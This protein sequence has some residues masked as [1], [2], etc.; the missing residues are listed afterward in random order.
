MDFFCNKFMRMPIWLLL[1][2]IVSF[3]MACNERSGSQESTEQPDKNISFNESD[4]IQLDGQTLTEADTLSR[5]SKIVIAGPYLIIKD[6]YGQPPIHVIRASD[7]SYVTALGTPGEGPGEFIGTWSFD[8]VSGDPPRFWIYDMPQLRL[9]YVDLEAYLRGA[10]ELGDRIINL[11]I[12]FTPTAPTWLSDSL[13]VS[14]G[15][16]TEEGRLAQFG[17]E[18]RFIGTAGISPPSRKGVPLAVLQHAYQSRMKPN[19]NR[20]LL[21]LGTFYA[22]RLEIYHFDGTRKVLAQGPA[23]FDPTFEVGILQG[24]PARQSTDETRYGYIDIATTQDR[25]YAL[26][27]GRLRNQQ[28]NHGDTVRVFDWNGN[29]KQVYDLN[30]AV[31]GITVDSTETTLYA[32]QRFPSL[33]ITRYSLPPP[34]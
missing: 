28:G 2:A 18:G 31:L 14:P 27:S 25:I 3:N 10:F 22:D 34:L 20:S 26:Y 15:F 33:E 13:L 6:A 19:P 24:E 11:N 30:A 8:V 23:H 4:V 17:P 9:T 12:G 1:L 21:A 29:L 16:L 5:P 32:T 7:G